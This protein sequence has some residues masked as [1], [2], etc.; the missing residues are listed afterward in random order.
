MS[1][2]EAGGAH[3]PGRDERLAR[4]VGASTWG[5]R[6]KPFPIVMLRVT[7]FRVDVGAPTNQHEKAARKGLEPL[8]GF[9]SLFDYDEHWR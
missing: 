9:R 8:G 6:G 5:S 2:R 4:P 1:M 7:S 3:A